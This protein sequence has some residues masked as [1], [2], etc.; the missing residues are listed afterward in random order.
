[1]SFKDISYLELWLRFCSSKWNH[2]CN[3]GRGYNEQQFCDSFRIEPVIQEML[4][5][6]FLILSSGSPPVQWS[7][8][9]YAILEEDIMGNIYVK[10]YEIWTSGSGGDVI[11]IK[12]LRTRDEDQ[13][14]YLTLSIRFRWA[15]KAGII[16]KAIINHV[17]L[18]KTQ[19]AD[20]PMA[21]GRS[22]SKRRH[23][24]VFGGWFERQ[25]P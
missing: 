10:L 1:M 3:Y 6:R 24:T 22:D 15:K 14:Q 21:P 18:T 7:G 20:Q 9:I 23:N 16:I 12:S 4:F 5:K 2:L 25:S 13:S 19:T 17:N 11:K 8:T